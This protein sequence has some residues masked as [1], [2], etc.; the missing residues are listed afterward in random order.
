MKEY[1]KFIEKA[2]EVGAN[3]A[4]IIKTD[5]I[6]TAVWVRW[7]CRYGCDGGSSLCCPTNSPTYKE[8]RE[9]IDCYKCAL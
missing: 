8:T 2:I 4:K 7:K 6:E 5:S 3:D 1:D 9:V